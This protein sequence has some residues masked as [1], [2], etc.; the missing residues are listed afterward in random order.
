[1]ASRKYAVLV[2][3]F[4][5]W[6]GCRLAK[7]I[8][9]KIWH[10]Q[11]IGDGFPLRCRVEKC[12]RC[13][14][15]AT[16]SH[17][18]DVSGDGLPH[19][20]CVRRRAP[21]HAMCPATGSHTRDVS[22]DGLPHTRCVRRRAPTHA[23]CPATGS[24][25]RDV[26]GDGLPH[27]RCVRRR[28]PTHAMCPATGSHTRDV[29]GDGLPHTRCVRRRAPTHAMAFLGRSRLVFTRRRVLEWSDTVPRLKLR[30]SRSWMTEY[31][32]FVLC[33]HNAIQMSRQTLSVMY[34]I[35]LRR[36]L[37]PCAR[38]TTFATCI[39]SLAVC[40][41]FVYSNMFSSRLLTIRTSACATY[42][43][44]S[45]ALQTVLSFLACARYLNPFPSHEAVRHDVRE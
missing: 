16:G 25:T 22:G 8:E 44:T 30:I 3:E 10:D 36:T 24:H 35:F 40:N 9:A 18:R 23:M 31:P 26:S 21:T 33:K 29:S 5:P 20:R 19:T 1:M 37:S 41:N 2:E 38:T 45:F 17:T 28:A 13:V 14:C 32:S 42:P 15:P 4:E 34:T 11:R 6:F 27:T 39:V 7:T 12:H 43:E